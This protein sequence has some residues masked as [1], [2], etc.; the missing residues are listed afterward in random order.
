[1]LFLLPYPELTRLPVDFSDMANKA[2]HLTNCP[3]A[4]LCSCWSAPS[5]EAANAGG[6]RRPLPTSCPRRREERK[7]PYP[8]PKPGRKSG[9]HPA[10]PALPAAADRKPVAEKT[11][12]QTDQARRVQSDP[13]LHQEVPRP[14]ERCEK[15]AKTIRA[16]K[17]GRKDPLDR[18]VFDGRCVLDI[19]NLDGPC[20]L[21]RRDHEPCSLTKKTKKTKKKKKKANTS[22]EQTAG[23]RGREGFA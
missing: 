23:Q 16:G 8:A 22:G 9:T 1:M 2:P 17:K 5:A 19:N 13:T 21:C 15:L 10:P 14:C 4:E 3:S 7:S 6:A 12:H 11:E 20:M 18:A